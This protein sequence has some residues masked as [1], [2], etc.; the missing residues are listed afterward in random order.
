MSGISV[1]RW[2]GLSLFPKSSFLHETPKVGL[3]VSPYR[4]SMGRSSSLNG[5]TFDPPA[6]KEEESSLLQAQLALQDM[7]GIIPGRGDTLLTFGTLTAM[8]VYI[9][10][11]AIYDRFA[12]D[13]RPQRRGSS[14]PPLC[15]K[16]HNKPGKKEEKSCPA[17]QNC[18]FNGAASHFLF[19]G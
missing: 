9:Y 11:S 17:M 13:F 1:K 7:L 14:L 12:L 15:Y 16:G 18:Y 19:Y 6:R 8:Y 10:S 4:E 3:L 5:T 2:P